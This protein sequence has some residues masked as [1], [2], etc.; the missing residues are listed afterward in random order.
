MKLLS[1]KQQIET[2][3]NVLKSSYNLCWSKDGRILLFGKRSLIAIDPVKNE[4]TIEPTRYGSAAITTGNRFGL[5][6]SLI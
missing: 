5:R 3:N 4:M 1:D 2:L 6:P